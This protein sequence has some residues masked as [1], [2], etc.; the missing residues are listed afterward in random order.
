MNQ[1]S[2]SQRIWE[3]TSDSN[4]IMTV[5]MG[6]LFAFCACLLFWDVRDLLSNGVAWDVSHGFDF[7]TYTLGA[8]YCFLFAY[9]FPA[10]HLKLA[11]LLLGTDYSVRL[12]TGH[13]GLSGSVQYS[14][15]IICSIARQI[16]FVIILFAIAQWRGPLDSAEPPGRH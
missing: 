16:A 15:S 6:L 12:V 8:V 2:R 1:S 10:K 14:A 3:I 9:S 13:L 5:G 4:W 7:I 11:F